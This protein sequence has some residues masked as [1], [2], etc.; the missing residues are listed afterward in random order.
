MLHSDENGRQRSRR[1][2]MA[3]KCRSISCKKTGE[4]QNEKGKSEV[5]K[6]EGRGRRQKCEG[7]SGGVQM[8]LH[9]SKLRF[10]TTALLL[11]GLGFRIIVVV[12]LIIMIIIQFLLVTSL[13]LS[14]QNDTPG[15]FSGE[16]TLIGAANVV[17]ERVP[18]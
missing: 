9:N 8:K 12:G 14:T 17:R 18:A 7:V 11:S 13:L 3:S 10:P 15:R 16:A 6:E 4:H 2:G 5:E 1:V